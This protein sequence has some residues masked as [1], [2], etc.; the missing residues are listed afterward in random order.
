MTVLHHQ[1]FHDSDSDLLNILTGPDP[2]ATFVRRDA[3]LD[4]LLIAAAAASG[5]HVTRNH[6]HHDFFPGVRLPQAETTLDLSKYTTEDASSR[7]TSKRLAYVSRQAPRRQR[8]EEGKENDHPLQNDPPKS[9]DNFLPGAKKRR[10][11]LVNSDIKYKSQKSHVVSESVPRP[12]QLSTPPLGVQCMA[13]TRIPTPH[14]PAFLHLYHNTRDSK[15]HL[16]IVIDPA[17]LSETSDYQLT[18]P[19]IR[20]QSLDA[21]WTKTETEMDRIVRGAYVGRLSA[22]SQHASNPLIQ[23]PMVDVLENIIPPPLIRIH[24]ECFTGET[25]GSMRCD[26]GEQLDEAIRRISQPIIVSSHPP[27]TIP[28]RGA[29]IYLRQEGRGI[30]LL[31][32]IRA[33][34]L[35]DMGH[36]TVT[37]NLMLGH[38]ADERGYEVAAAILRDLSLG[39]GTSSCKAE[40]VRVLTNNPDKVEALEK[41]G[42]RVVERVAM[43]PRS[44]GM[45]ADTDG[46]HARVAGATLI[47]GNVVYGEDLDKYLRTK[48]LRMGHI[49]PL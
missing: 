25:V 13:R 34:N 33:Y 36:D 45:S 5:P 38:K 8:L 26:C 16:A 42:I 40:G 31:S 43:I 46:L 2:K 7:N 18:A 41:E 49:L 6:Y 12:I 14:G 28:G 4:P 22:T 15:E 44:W 20:S 37:A 10:M 1:R 39:S 19:S 21:I 35:Q 23:S 24:S 3:A 30:G 11:T 29:V 32:K 27:T 9:A 48:I 47:G 17:Q